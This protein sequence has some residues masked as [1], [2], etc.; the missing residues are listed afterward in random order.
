MSID[1]YEYR[2]RTCPHCK[3]KRLKPVGVVWLDDKIWSLAVGTVSRTGYL[4]RNCKR[5]IVESNCKYIYDRKE[6]RRDVNR[7][8]KFLKES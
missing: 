7:L 2:Y 8:L 4:C 1:L 6:I 5:Y 3:S